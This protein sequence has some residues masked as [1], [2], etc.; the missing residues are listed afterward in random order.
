MVPSAQGE[1][2]AG[3]IADDTTILP[4]PA[5]SHNEPAL[6]HPDR[7]LNDT[8]SAYYYPELSKLPPP[9]PSPHPPQWSEAPPPPA[10]LPPPPPQIVNNNFVE[11][12]APSVPMMSA[13]PPAPPAAFEREA[14]GPLSADSSSSYGHP[15]SDKF[16]RCGFG[17]LPITY[18][19]RDTRVIYMK[20]MAAARQHDASTHGWMD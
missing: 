19:G 14:D 8:P 1:D 11:D 17:L 18:G 13:P 15:A 16:V 5:A 12:A 2:A 9:A 4:L 7:A 10:P 6:H 20:R 3:A